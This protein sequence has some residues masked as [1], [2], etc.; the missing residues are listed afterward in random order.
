MLFVSAEY[1]LKATLSYKLPL[2]LDL[3]TTKK[4]YVNLRVSLLSIECAII[5]VICNKSQ[6]FKRGDFKMK[7]DAGSVYETLC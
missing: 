7:Q 5:I 3:N 1:V 4:G 2:N 6:R